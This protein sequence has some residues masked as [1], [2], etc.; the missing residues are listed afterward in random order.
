MRTRKVYGFIS[1]WGKSSQCGEL[2]TFERAACYQFEGADLKRFPE[3]EMIPGLIVVAEITEPGGDIS[4]EEE[5]VSIEVA[6]DWEGKP[7]V[8]VKADIFTKIKDAVEGMSE[9]L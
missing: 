7:R 8:A 2:E 4:R 5:V 1:Q 9:F 3:S 6:W